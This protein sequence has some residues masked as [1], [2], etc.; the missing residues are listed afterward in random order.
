MFYYDPTIL[1]LIPALIISMI[2]QSR[3]TST[4][5][6]FLR[7]PA[8]R[9]HSGYEVAQSMLANNGINNVRIEP[10][11]GTLTDHYDPKNKVLRLS[12]PVY[13]GASIAALSV[14]AHEVGHAIQDAEGYGALRFRNAIAPAVAIGSNF[15]WILILLGLFMASRQLMQIGVFLFLGVVIFQLITLPVEFNA[16]NRAIE[17][18]ENGFITRDEVPAA[19]KVLGAAAMTYVAATLVS[20]AQLARIFM[21]TRRRD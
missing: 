19:K 4:Y 18:L 2:A 5:Q 13:N 1:I 9:G 6:K 21:L 15:V 14:A 7:V 17:H 16:S 10:V 12:Q 20:I 8:Q 3:V 11:Q